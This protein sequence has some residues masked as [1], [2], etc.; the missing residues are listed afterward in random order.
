MQ[1]QTRKVRTMATYYTERR[2]Q[3]EKL[4]YSLDEAAEA[5]GVSRDYFDDHIRHE[6]KLVRRGRRVF[7]A[8]TALQAWLDQAGERVLP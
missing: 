6:L 8:K 5:L 7:V 1:H 4:A 3:L 2:S